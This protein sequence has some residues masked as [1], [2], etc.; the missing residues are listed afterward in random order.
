MNI[1]IAGLTKRYRAIPALEDVSL[2]IDP[3]QTVALL[4]PNGAGKSTMLRCLAG[5]VSPDAG[6][7]FYDDERFHRD[8]IDLRQRYFLMPDFPFVFPQMSVIRHIGMVLRLYGKAGEEIDDTVIDLLREFDMLPLAEA[9]LATLS[10][11]QSYKAALCALLAADPE[12]WM[13]DEPFASGMD[14]R[15]LTAFR[16]RCR[17]AVYRG[18]TVL[19]TTQILDVAERFSDKVCIIHQGKV[20]AFENVNRLKAEV[21]EANGSIL[22]AVFDQLHEEAM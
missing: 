20:H 22:E 21:T 19:Y 2:R 11:G 1:E 16:R 18:R 9:R 3:G 12:L 7:I 10:R 15:G 5:I 6:E 13:F 17:D 4:G 8:R 14:P